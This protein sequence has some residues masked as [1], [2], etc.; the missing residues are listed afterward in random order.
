MAQESMAPK[1][2]T[3]PSS[4]YKRLD[5]AARETEN[6]KKKAA[7]NIANTLQRSAATNT[8]IPAE[9]APA[10]RNSGYKTTTG[11]SKQY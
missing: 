10:K 11:Y 8:S 1:S 6:K 3:G 9:S 5:T 4:I 7:Q 2:G